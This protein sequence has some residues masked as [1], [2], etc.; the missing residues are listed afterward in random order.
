MRLVACEMCLVA[1]EIRLATLPTLSH[2]PFRSFPH[3]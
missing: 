3:V 2:I 1:C